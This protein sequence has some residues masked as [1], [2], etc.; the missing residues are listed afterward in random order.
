MKWQGAAILF[1]AGLALLAGCGR[2][3]NT[4]PASTGGKGSTGAEGGSATGGAAID[5][6]PPCP[7]TPEGCGGTGAT[8]LGGAA[9]GGGNGAHAGSDGGTSAG[10]GNS[11]GGVSFG[12]SPGIAPAHPTAQVDLL[13]MIDNSISM[14]DKQM[15]LADAMPRLLERLVTPTCVD[16]N[17]EPTGYKAVGDAGCPEGSPEFA[18]V[19]DLHIGVITSSLGAHGGQT[20]A[21]ATADDKA[22]LI[23]KIRSP[24]PSHPYD[25]W[26]DSGFLAWDPD[27]E[28]NT[29]PGESDFGVFSDN[30][31]NMIQS[32]GQTGCGYEASLEAWYR[33]LIDPDPPTQ[34]PQVT[35]ASQTTKPLFPAD[36]A[37]N[38]V[39][40]Q[41]AAFLRPDS[42]L[43]IVVLSD[44][45]DCSIVD[46]G[47][48]WLVGA[49]NLNGSGAFHMPRSRSVCETNPNDECC[50]SCS[51]SLPAGCSSDPTCGTAALSATEDNLNLRCWDQKR[52]FG[53]ELLYPLARYVTGLTETEVPRRNGT[54]VRNPLFP[55]GGR[56][57]SMVFLNGIIGVPWQDLASKASLA[58]N[59]P[60]EYLSHAELTAQGRWALVLGE[61]G[62]SATAPTLPSDLLMFE[63]SKD[64]S[65]LFGAAGHPLLGVQAVLTPAS[66]STR[67]NAINGH[68]TNIVDNSDLQYAC[69]FPLPT[70]KDC[71]SGAAACDCKTADSQLNRALCN[72]TTQTH[73]KAYPSVRQL[74]VLK[75][76]GDLTGNAVPTSIC[77][78]TLVASESYGYGPAV[79]ALVSRLKPVLV[80]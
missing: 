66:E 50:L 58:A 13:F 64:R 35:D 40:V 14:A 77:P 68:E 71:A 62:D 25:T 12:G 79:S 70:S 7:V 21:E 54:L 32:V 43:V 44:E 76:F 38:P 34:I 1:G 6:I 28:R 9:S 30:L 24:D 2:T 19:N 47:L 74:R 29:P 55:E 56:T 27:S 75:A 78:K 15:V 53:F 60:L 20:C 33:F 65:T 48:G 39:L 57:P 67:A 49:Q 17:G 42:A 16:A 10:E 63:T 3:E 59:T 4:P 18:P 52:R 11:T 61:E 69:I 23:G 46:E 45:N 73:A 37:Q 80:H 22:Q 5:G 26:N 31:A 51:A 41:R 72:G 36:P 8:G